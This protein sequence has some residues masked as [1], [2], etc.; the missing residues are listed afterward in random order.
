MP[1]RGRT[2]NQSPSERVDISQKNRK[3]TYPAR[4]LNRERAMV[5]KQSPALK[6]IY[7]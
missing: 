4:A 2:Q 3:Y 1:R 6:N 5:N 7:K